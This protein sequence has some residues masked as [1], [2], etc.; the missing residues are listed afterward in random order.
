M[1]RIMSKDKVWDPMWMC[2]ATMRPAVTGS[3]M[4]EV[5]SMSTP[6]HKSTTQRTWASR[7]WM[8]VMMKK[9]KKIMMRVWMGTSRQGRSRVTLL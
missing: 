9:E 8:M 5:L 1:C 7:R 2:R 3:P 4:G 6:A